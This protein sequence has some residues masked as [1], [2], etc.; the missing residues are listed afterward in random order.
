MKVGQNIAMRSSTAK[1]DYKLINQYH[2]DQINAWFNEVKNYKYSKKFT[3]A[4]QP[5]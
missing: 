4:E 1:I 3:A 5:A 2:I